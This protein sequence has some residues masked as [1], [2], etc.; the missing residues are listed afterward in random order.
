L[1]S[2]YSTV[3]YTALDE[4]SPNKP[5]RKS[6]P[7]YV[8]VTLNLYK[9]EGC[10]NI[11]WEICNLFR[12]TKCMLRAYLS[13]VKN[14]SA[15]REVLFSYRTD[16]LSA[17]SQDLPIWQFTTRLIILQF[18]LLWRIWLFILSNLLLLY[19]SGCFQ[20]ILALNLARTPFFPA[21]L[22]L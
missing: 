3:K 6:L 13:S 7:E 9:S 12:E 20:L 22:A 10:V 5:A 1:S 8:Y 2:R 21:H 18:I 4:G 15:G 17:I 19:L 16:C 14:Y 11:R